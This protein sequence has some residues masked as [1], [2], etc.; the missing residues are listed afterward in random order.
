MNKQDLLQMWETIR[1]E[2]WKSQETFVELLITDLV[3]AQNTL[4]SFADDKYVGNSGF[5]YTDGYVKEV[6]ADVLGKS[7]LQ[8]FLKQKGRAD[9]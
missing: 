4:Q 2:S 6:V 8:S 1:N 9:E 3:D 7:G 5:K